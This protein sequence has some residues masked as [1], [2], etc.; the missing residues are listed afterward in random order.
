M[1]QNFNY[2]KLH[3][4][5]T[6]V[7]FITYRLLVDKSFHSWHINYIKYS[8]KNFYFFKSLCNKIH[9]LKNNIRVSVSRV[10]IALILSGFSY[11]LIQGHI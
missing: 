10:D 6:C 8:P 7:V 5:F 3:P 1:P 9:C 2:F 4:T 11:L